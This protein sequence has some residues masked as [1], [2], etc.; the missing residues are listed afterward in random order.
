MAFLDNFVGLALVTYDSVDHPL[1]LESLSLFPGQSHLWPSLLLC[2]MLLLGPLTDFPSSLL[3]PS[4]EVMVPQGTIL[5][6]LLPSL[7]ASSG[8]SFPSHSQGLSDNPKSS[9][10]PSVLSAQ[11]WH[12]A[13][14]A[15]INLMALRC[16]IH[17]CTCDSVPG[18]VLC[19]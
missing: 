9:Q 4:V 16:L 13:A 2:S 18:T 14:F 19:A 5:S 6:P 7:Y 17:S 11:S 12:P 1:L 15:P 10:P 8:D 3:S